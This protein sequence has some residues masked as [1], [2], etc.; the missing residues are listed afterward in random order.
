[1]TSLAQFLRSVNSR[2]VRAAMKKLRRLMLPVLVSLVTVGLLCFIINSRRPSAQASW[3]GTASMAGSV[4]SPASDAPA[5]DVPGADSKPAPDLERSARAQAFKAY[6]DLSGD[7]WRAP[8][9]LRSLR[10]HQ[11]A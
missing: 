11:R 8:L 2:G 6:D 7:G 4:K 5:A 10:L 9:S 1:M 3:H